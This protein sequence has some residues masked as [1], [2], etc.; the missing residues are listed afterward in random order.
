MGKI[1]TRPSS[2]VTIAAAALTAATTLA[3]AQDVTDTAPAPPSIETGNGQHN[4]IMVEGAVRTGATFR[5]P[6]VRIDR[7]GFLVM[8]PFRDGTPVPTEYVAAVPVPQG[9]S[10]NVKITPNDSPQ[11][12]DMYIVMLH[13]DMNDDRIFD[14]NDGVA[15]PDAPVFEGNRMI[16]LRYVTPADSSEQQP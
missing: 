6:M 14:F 10:H 15:V 11:T 5:F 4:A 9:I 1:M 13:Y 12:G 16:A 3:G 7:N 2:I 8:H